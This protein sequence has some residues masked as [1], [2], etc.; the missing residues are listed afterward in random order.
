MAS[1]EGQAP[2]E[3]R[4]AWVL[5]HVGLVVAIGGIAVAIVLCVGVFLA[6]SW[7]VLVDER[8]T[9]PAKAATEDKVRTL[10]LGIVTVIG[11]AIAGA[12]AWGRLDLSRQEN[13]RG[14]SLLATDRYTR[15][16]EQ[17]GSANSAVRLG[18]LYAL[19]ALA[20]DSP[21]DRA[22]IAEV[23][24]AYVRHHSAREESENPPLPAEEQPPGA[25]AESAA[26]SR[27]ERL[28][29]AGKTVD[30]RAALSIA[31]RLPAFWQLPTRDLRGIV[32]VDLDAV[33][34]DLGTVDF[35]DA[36]FLGKTWFHGARFRGPAMFNKAVFEGGADFGAAVFE[37]TADFS[38]AE[39][40]AAE[41]LANYQRERAGSPWFLPK[42][43]RIRSLHGLRHEGHEGVR[44]NYATFKGDASF[45]DTRFECWGAHF[46][47]A[48]FESQLAF[49]PRGLNYC[50]F[51][52]AEFREVVEMY[53]PHGFEKVHFNGSV[54]QRGTSF[55]QSGSPHGFEQRRCPDGVQRWFKVDADR[56]GN[57]DPA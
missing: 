24:C 39:F 11:A 8:L 19:E 33:G 16:I 2:R 56:Q 14:D 18:A 10:A 34:C 46:E 53:F 20:H 42:D 3:V 57:L 51:E 52:S 21:G 7:N 29:K 27:F 6:P 40:T 38:F 15:A 23:I 25:S 47:H 26:A 36:L 9:G 50:T 55:N 31:L 17:L 13:R 28:R 4:E 54:F 43:E 32:A 30:Q 37:D 22:A 48:V 35:R 44:F 41:R 1:A 12:L 49:E 5:R 45:A